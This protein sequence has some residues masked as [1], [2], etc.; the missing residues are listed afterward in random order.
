M[1]SEERRLAISL[2]QPPETR[3]DLLADLRI[4]VILHLETP[5]LIT[6]A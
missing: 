2:K 5:A 3:V 6:G 1:N 4:D